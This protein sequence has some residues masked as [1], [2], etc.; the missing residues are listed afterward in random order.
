MN[1]NSFE[2]LVFLPV[3]LLLYWTIPHK[4]RWILLLVASYY[5]YMSWNAWLVF[6]ILGT[7]VIS[8]LSGIL[9]GSTKKQGRKKLYVIVTLVVCLGT[10]VFFKYFNFLLSSVIDFLNLFSLHIESRTLDI[11]LPVGISFYTF[12]TLSYVID[13]YRGKF[14]P[15]KHFGYYALF[16]SYFPQLVAGP[17]EK[18]G[19]LLPQL[20]EKHFLNREDMEIGFKTMVC[21]FFRKCVVADFCGI[22]VNRVF[23]DLP[24]ATGLAVW[25]AGAFFCIQMY[26]D[27]AGYSEIAIG[28]AR[29]MGV[30]LTKNFDRPYFSQSY[31]EFFRRWHI[32]LNRWFTEYLYIPLGGNR[33]GKARKILNTVVVFS[34][35][36][37]WHGANW[38]YLLWGLYAAFFVCAESILPWKPSTTDMGILGRRVLMFFIFVPAGIIFRA[39]SVA[40]IGQAFFQIFYG[41]ENYLVDTLAFVGLDFFGLARFFVSLICMELFC[42]FVDDRKSFKQKSSIYAY[43]II[44]VMLCWI[45]LLSTGDISAFQYFQF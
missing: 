11:I 9:I 3:V 40:Q 41:T 44:A 21:G 13:V 23:S 12:Q 1:F 33:K 6:A 16:V 24:H 19:D 10:L 42:D 17:I 31:T 7:T 30:K 27:F 38:T 22:Y 45:A 14:I 36:G 25:I 26:C 20:R 39:E 4:F 43:T 2:F 34:L 28:C 8:Y 15:E 37:M 18:P 29:M 35:C 5:F 32:T